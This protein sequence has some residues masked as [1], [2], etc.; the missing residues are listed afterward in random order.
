MV[1][2]STSDLEHHGSGEKYTLPADV[3]EMDRLKLQQH[4]WRLLLQ[5]LYPATLRGSINRILNPEI[6]RPTILDLGCGA[7]AW[8]MEMALAFP[9][10]EV[11]GFDLSPHPVVAPG[12][13][14]NYCFVQGN[15][16]EC[17]LEDLDLHHKFDL[18]HCRSVLW[19]QKDPNRMIEV[20][21]SCLKPGGLALIVD[22][23]ESDRV[24][25]KDRELLSPDE[26]TTGPGDVKYSRFANWIKTYTKVA[27]GHSLTYD[28]ATLLQ[29]LSPLNWEG[30]DVVN[31]LEIGAVA[32]ESLRKVFPA[33]KPVMLRNGMSPQTFED[34]QE[35]L[36][37]EMET[38]KIYVTW[39]VVWGFRA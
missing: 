2:S 37:E 5:G 7:G 36:F 21:A 39:Q 26:N 20:I 25:D 3:S 24:Y 6:G 30:R 35:K 32:H 33:T 38:L 14:K 16:L 27:R 31:G 34:M 13:P 12:P 11:T 8:E 10:A 18:V 19:H 4:M 1:P 22:G 9:L 28:Y 15:A 29:I 23:S 17:D